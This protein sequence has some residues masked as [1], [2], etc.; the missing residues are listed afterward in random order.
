MLS[1]S[2]FF[3]YCWYSL[4]PFSERPIFDGILTHYKSGVW[5]SHH[6]E[7]EVN[8]TRNREAAGSIPGLA[9][10]VGDPGLP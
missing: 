4:R 8:L 1:F 9:Q 10:W 5:S 3:Q 7:V 6:G 2:T